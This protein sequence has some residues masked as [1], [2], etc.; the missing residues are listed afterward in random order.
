M[1]VRT[2]NA[3]EVGG[4][5]G[6]LRKRRRGAA[7]VSMER[8]F[9]GSVYRGCGWVSGDF[10]RGPGSRFLEVNWGNICK[11]DFFN[12][13]C[14]MVIIILG[15]WDPGG[16]FVGYCSFVLFSFRFDFK[17]SETGE[18]WHVSGTFC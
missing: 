14:L 17:I 5:Q 1:K 7:D 2:G 6:G 4:R 16:N 3:R 8:R 15:E 11:F 13:A 9:D 18:D 10:F 12:L